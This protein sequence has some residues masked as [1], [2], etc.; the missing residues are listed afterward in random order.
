MSR[1]FLLTASIV[2]VAINVAGGIYAYMTNEV[3]HGLA[4]GAFAVGFGL[5]A[6]YLKSTDRGAER[7]VEQ[8]DRVELLQNDLSDLERELQE[9]RA[10]LDFADQL[11]KKKPPSN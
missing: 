4:H 11:L 3:M 7:R 2:L 1:K 10:R 8:P 6:R 5:W 9:T